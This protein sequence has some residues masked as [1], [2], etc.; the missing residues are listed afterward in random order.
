MGL[1]NRTLQMVV[2]LMLAIGSAAGLISLKLIYPRFVALEHDQARHNAEMVVELLNR[3]LDLLS[4]QSEDWSYWDDT[5]RFA[6]ERNADFIESN[7]GLDTQTSL[8]ANFLGFYDTEGRRIWSRAIALESGKRLDMPELDR[9]QLPADHPLLAH[10]DVITVRSG[11]LVTGHGPMLATASP[12]LQSD[13]SGPYRGTLIFGRFFNLEAVRRIAREGRLAVAFSAPA[14]AGEKALTASGDALR[15]RHSPFEFS[16]GATG[17]VGR[18]VLFGIDDRPALAMTVGTPGDISARGRSVL[19]LA[20]IFLTVASVL[21]CGLLIAMLNREIVVPVQR[22]TELAQRIGDE[23]DHTARVRMD[24]DDEIGELGR[25]FDGML[26]RLADARRRLLDQSYKAGASEMAGGIIRDLR[27]S[28]GPIREKLESP[29]RLLDQAQ[30]SG[31]QMLV[32]QLGDPNLARPKYA[33]VL[34]MLQENISEQGAVLSEA[35]AELR[36]LRRHLEQSQNTLNEYARY[37]DSKTT[38]AP[39]SLSALLD[40]AVRLLSP[41]LR[42]GLIL[43]IDDSVARVGNVVAAREVLQQVIHVVIQH[44]AL[45]LQSLP[46]RQGSLRITASIEQGEDHERVHLR[47]DDNRAT[48]TAEDMEQMF[49]NDASRETHAEGLSLPWAASVMTAMNG[50]LFATASQPFDGLLLH[51]VLPRARG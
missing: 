17:V 51:L 19:K 38:L 7:L 29:L 48:P 23:G 4:P 18:T 35:R 37:L 50:E 15:L 11:L 27:A 40:H 2:I 36:V 8:K 32:Q 20:A 22:L 14:T 46:D 39:I 33:E 24:R 45:A 13:R 41:T 43:D 28:L 34:Q 16:S 9:E 6:L 42:A 31:Q 10:G 5:Y 47:F 44:S 3:E 25:E 30:T 49:L 21:A 26:D 1:R 12:I